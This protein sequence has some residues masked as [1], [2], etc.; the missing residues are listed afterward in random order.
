MKKIFILLVLG[1]CIL[2]AAA[3]HAADQAAAVAPDI[4]LGD[5]I[6]GL[7]TDT[8]I[9]LVVSLVG[10][11]LSAVLIKLKKKFNVQ[12]SAETE[13]WINKQAENAVQMVAEKA[14]AKI[15]YE[16]IQLT[17]SEKLNMAI[18]ALV[19]KVPKVTRDQAD[20]YIHAALARISGLGATG[21]KALITG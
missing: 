18:A 19:T 5:A 17:G 10:A 20:Q 12:L 4:T 2:S 8:V 11:L 9:P 21:D 3:T 6:R 13:D 16:N 7:V 14:A 1:V 15:K